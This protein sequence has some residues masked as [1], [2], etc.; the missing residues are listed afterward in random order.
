M[1]LTRLVVPKGKVI[2]P[3][4]APGEIVVQC[5]EGR[6]TL[7]CH[8]TLVKLG[9]GDMVHLGAGELHSLAALENASVLVTLVRPPAWS[10]PESTAVP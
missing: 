7:R 9:A 10:P 6:V 8:E 2:P 3:H 1:Q 4:K 5:V